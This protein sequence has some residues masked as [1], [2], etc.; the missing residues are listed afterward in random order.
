MKKRMKKRMRITATRTTTTTKMKKS[1]MTMKRTKKTKEMTRM[2][3]NIDGSY[4]GEYNYSASAHQFFP[5]AILT[6]LFL[7]YPF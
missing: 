6:V 1:T 3:R 4:S 7:C 2:R 5:Y